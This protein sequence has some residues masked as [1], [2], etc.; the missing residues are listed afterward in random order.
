[1]RL[2]LRTMAVALFQ[3]RCCE[4]LSRTDLAAE[5][6]KQ[7]GSGGEWSAR[8]SGEPESAVIE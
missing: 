8:D 3:S 4:L 7:P 1:M 2:S 5:D 6:G